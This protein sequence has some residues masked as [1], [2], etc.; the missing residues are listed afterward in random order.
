M[1]NNCK[2]ALKYS[3]GD[4]TKGLM[5]SL[6]NYLLSNGFVSYPEGYEPQEMSSATCDFEIRIIKKREKKPRN[7]KITI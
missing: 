2:R 6:G 1:C 4:D 5:N 7:E 3:K